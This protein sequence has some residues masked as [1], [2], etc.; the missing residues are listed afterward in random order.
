VARVCGYSMILCGIVAGFVAA[1]ARGEEVPLQFRQE[2][3]W[4]L[5]GLS[6]V[7]WMKIKEANMP[8]SKVELLLKAG[9]AISEY[10]ERP[11]E[12]LGLTEDDWV[13]NRQL[14]MEDEDMAPRS[15][16]TID[17]WAPIHNF[18]VPGLHHY[19]RKQYLKAYTMSGVAVAA[20]G[21]TVYS[22]V[23]SHQA[24]ENSFSPMYPALILIAD[25]LWSSVDILVQINRDKNP[26]AKRFSLDISERI[27]LKVHLAFNGGE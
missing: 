27:E 22:I 20:A 11:W 13:R 12:R 7:E 8:M 26:E 4:E 5:L 16:A 10:F 18:F 2:K 17:D 6:Q 24:S 14:G 9:I 1:T 21:L 23:A 25:M 3:E 19:G 15:Q